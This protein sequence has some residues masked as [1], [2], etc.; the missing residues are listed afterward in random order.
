MATPE[1]VHDNEAECLACFCCYEPPPPPKG[2]EDKRI[3]RP[4][5]VEPKTHFANER[6]FLH[7]LSCT[8]LLSTMGLR[9]LKSETAGPICVAASYSI[10]FCSV[11]F[12][13]YALLTF[14]GRQ[15]RI[16]AAG[17]VRFDDVDGPMVLT[18]VLIAGMS[19]T[20]LT[21]MGFSF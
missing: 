8:V 16:K 6:T 17:R 1:H 4:S 12:M 3:V 15:Q 21:E 9:V 10:L 19:V 20:A 14:Y 5:I 18:V 7:W 2:T 11:L 13:V